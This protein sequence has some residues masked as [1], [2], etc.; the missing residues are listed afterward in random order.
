MDICVTDSTKRYDI[1]GRRIVGIQHKVKKTK[2]RKG[3]PTRVAILNPGG[4]RPTWHD[5]VSLQAERDFRAGHLVTEY[6]A[7]TPDEDLSVFR[8]YQ[9]VWRDLKKDEVVPEGTPDSQ[10]RRLGRRESKIQI[11]EKVPATYEG[12]REGDVVVTTF[13][14]L[15]LDYAVS[16][17]RYVRE[18]GIPNVLVLGVLPGDLKVAREALGSSANKTED[19][20]VL[21]YLAQEQSD[22]TYPVMDRELKLLSIVAAQTHLDEAMRS[23]VAEH[24][25]V[26]ARLRRDATTDI[27]SSV[28]PENE[29]LSLDERLINKADKHPSVVALTEEE[30]RL[31]SALDRLLEA[32]PVYADLL[33]KVE[34]VGPRIAGR[35]IAGIGD[36]R[37]F[38]S[39]TKLIAYAG[40]LPREGKL[41]RRV[42]GVP[43]RYQP[44]LRQGAY[45][46]SEQVNK[47]PTSAWG[48]TFRECKARYAQRH[49]DA[50]P[51][52]IHAGG[53][54]NM[55]QKFLTWIWKEWSRLEN[56]GHLPDGYAYRRNKN[57]FARKI[58]SGEL[59]PE[60]VAQIIESGKRRAEE[61]R[62]ARTAT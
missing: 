47:M 31:E 48:I 35:L 14:G 58:T 4:K 54:W 19:A 7:P 36:I 10:I 34:G 60:R 20:E 40:A 38:E 5:L 59:T 22:L 56:G 39:P 52:Q 27:S 11:L 37:R 44:K 15:G 25:R 3:S 57:Y 6:R 53:R 41:V 32:E 42:K 13:A 17:V 16:I 28:I 1:T 46:F 43:S 55:I 24:H 18:R 9:L 45:L 21:I 33:A 61:A 12:I 30:D 51:G 49:P 8:P 62:V 23:R 50:K 2:D 26:L 29:E